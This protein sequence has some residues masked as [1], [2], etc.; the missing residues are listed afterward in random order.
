MLKSASLLAFFGLLRASEYLSKNSRHFD[1]E[2]TLLF[3]DIQFNNIFS[4]VTIHIKKSKTDPF[5]HGCYIK[6][7]AVNSHYCPVQTLRL[8]YTQN[9]FEGPLFQFQNGSYLTRRTFSDIIQLCL[10]QTYLNT[11]SF[12]IGGASA[13]FTAGIPETTIQTLGRWASNAYRLY[14]RIPNN[15]IRE[16]QSRMSRVLQSN[17]WHPPREDKDER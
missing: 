5:R 3:H 2:D 6:V 15:T 4:H 8:Y 7:W 9:M 13:A 1:P 10:P 11:H 17:P 14:L 16:A 12:R